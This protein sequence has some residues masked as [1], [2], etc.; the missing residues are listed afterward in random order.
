M[1]FR[2]EI[3][4]LFAFTYYAQLEKGLFEYEYDHVFIGQFDGIPNPSPDEVDDWKWID[5]PALKIEIETNPFADAGAIYAFNPCRR[6]L[7]INR[8]RWIVRV[9]LHCQ[10]VR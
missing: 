6:F 2:C 4:K 5:L 9:C 7:P 3:K 10:T 8:V 1:G